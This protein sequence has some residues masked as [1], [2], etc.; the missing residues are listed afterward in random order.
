MDGSSRSLSRSFLYWVAQNPFIAQQLDHPKPTFLIEAV[1]LFWDK[2]AAIKANGF[3]C[4]LH[5]CFLRH[6]V[7]QIKTA[8]AKISPMKTASPIERMASVDCFGAVR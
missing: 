5:W 3:S 1:C 7:L 6:W 4:K 8:A 2:I